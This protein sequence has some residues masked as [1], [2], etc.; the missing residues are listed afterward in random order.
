[1]TSPAVIVGIDGGL[2]TCGL[3]VIS[4]DGT[5]HVCL[6]ADTFASEPAKDVDP[7]MPEDRVRRARALA[8]WLRGYLEGWKPKLVVAERM[9]FARGHNQTV[10]V[11]LGWGVIA[12]ELDRL[13]LSLVCATAQQWRRHLVD[14]GDENDS[15]MAA[16]RF[17]PSSLRC[18][19]RVPLR[20]Q[21][22]AL[23][24]LG[25]FCWGLSTDAMRGVMRAT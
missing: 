13:S 18:I 9:G 19:E 15:H 3:V 12:A 23:D 7:E 6:A 22:H 20:M 17:V 11:A 2:A 1:M 21:P 4:T 5:Q 14:S 8:R 16:I 25:V 24:A 10:C